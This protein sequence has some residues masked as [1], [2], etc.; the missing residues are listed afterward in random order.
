MDTIKIKAFLSAVKHKSLSKAAEEFSYTPSAFSHMADSLEE[1]LGVKVLVRTSQGV[2]LSEEGELL[3]SKLQAVV[4]AEKELYECASTLAGKK[5]NT[6]KIASYSSIS[7]NLLPE[8]LMG[9]RKEYPEVKYSMCVTDDVKTLLEN[10]E[11]DII[12]A[13]S[14]GIKGVEL[15]P[16]MEEPYLVA[17]KNDSFLRKKSVNKEELYEYNYIDMGETLLEDYFELERFS[18]IIKVETHE[19]ATVLSMIKGGLGVAVLPALAV[20]NKQQGIKTLGLEPSISRT[21]GYAVRKGIKNTGR[22]FQFVKY[23]QKNFSVNNKN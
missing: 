8:I 11:V 5:G 4:D 3:Y 13:D 21:I 20:K 23:L 7:E 17:T 19:F 12:F 1:E 10:G 22:A 2:D 18:D 15:I 16:L 6:L 9:F 14:T